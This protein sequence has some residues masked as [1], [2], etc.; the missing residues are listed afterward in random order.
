VDLA[1]VARDVVASLE[2]TARSRGVKVT[3]DLQ[4]ALVAG[5]AERLRELVHNLAINAIEYNRP[6]GS[7]HVSTSLDGD[8]VRLQVRDSGIGI[9]AGELPRIFDRFYRADSSRGRAVGGSG[10]GLAIAKWIVEEHGGTIACDSDRSTG[11]TFTS[12]LPAR[13]MSPDTASADASRRDVNAPG[14]QGAAASGHAT[15]PRGPAGDG[16]R[17]HDRVDAVRSGC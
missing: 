2:T 10:L 15:G 14:A 16:G 11:T 12:T 4:P 1:E 5:D 8:I 17:E 3:A 9:D 7:V 13:H 6:A